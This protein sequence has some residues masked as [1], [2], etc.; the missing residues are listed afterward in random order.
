MTDVFSNHVL[1]YFYKS[2][3]LG[4]KSILK[5]TM[6][7][8]IYFFLFLQADAYII[9]IITKMCLFILKIEYIYIDK[10]YAAPGMYNTMH[11]V[12]LSLCIYVYH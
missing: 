6:L 7:S 1:N 3:D 11:G 10:L 9:F 8:D 12:V 5:L 2:L 4:S